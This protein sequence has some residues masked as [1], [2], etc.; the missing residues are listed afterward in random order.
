MASIQVNIKCKTG[1]ICPLCQVECIE[2]WETVCNR[3][4]N[5]LGEIDRITGSTH[6]QQVIDNKKVV[7]RLPAVI[8]K[9]QTCF[10]PLT[11]EERR[12]R[13]KKIIAEQCSECKKKMKA[14]YED[15]CWTCPWQWMM[16]EIL[17]NGE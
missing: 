8:H 16:N 15:P 2:A 11:P 7:V 6:Q 10:Y 1:K 17:G 13:I 3:C 5:F 14:G 12:R 4:W 9:V